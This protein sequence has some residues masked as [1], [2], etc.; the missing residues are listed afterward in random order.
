LGARNYKK[1]GGGGGRIYWG[2][3]GH[4]TRRKRGN[5]K[6][7]SNEGGSQVAQLKGK[8]E[9]WGGIIVRRDKGIL[10]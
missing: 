4:R 5:T 9:A 10:G 3:T 6:S 7:I 1:K 2:Q 8:R